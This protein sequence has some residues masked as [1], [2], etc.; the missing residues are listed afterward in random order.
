MKTMLRLI[1][2]VHT[3]AA[4]ITIAI[5]VSGAGLDLSREDTEAIGG[6]I[7]LVLVLMGIAAQ[8]KAREGRF[9]APLIALIT[10]PGPVFAYLGG[11]LNHVI[12]YHVVAMAIHGLVVYSIERARKRSGGPDGGAR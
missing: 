6:T 2:T 11:S 12:G 10:L 5:L 9:S 8:L 3:T 7:T 4:V 1:I